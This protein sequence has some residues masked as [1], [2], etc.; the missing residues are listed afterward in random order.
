MSNCW[1]VPIRMGLDCNYINISVHTPLLYQGSGSGSGLGFTVRNANMMDSFPNS[2]IPRK[3]Y[4]AHYF[5]T[6][7][8]FSCHPYLEVRR[9][10]GFHTLVYTCNMQVISEGV[11]T[12]SAPGA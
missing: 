12:G 11:L 9:I 7:C 1:G 2:K 4:R 5:N 8:A 6:I 10:Q 3:P